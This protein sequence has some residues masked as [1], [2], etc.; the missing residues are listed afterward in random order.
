MT[1]AEASTDTANTSLSFAYDAGGLRTGKTVTT[2]THEYAATVIQPTC[3]EGGYTVHTCACGDSYQDSETDPL[4]H[5]YTTTVVEPTCTQSG[6]T[7]HACTACGHSYSDS[8]TNPLGH[9]YAKTGEDSNYVYYA[10]T[11][12]GD[13]YTE[14]HVHS[15]TV[16]V[17]E[18][19]CTEGGIRFIHVAAVAT[20]I[21][22]T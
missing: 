13:S 7:F 22:I 2:H 20:A 18:P 17:V 11:R 6:Y 9:H 10:C 21:K 15:Y 1:E 12:C 8:A 16:T 5:S 19:A 14:A 3:T 4:G